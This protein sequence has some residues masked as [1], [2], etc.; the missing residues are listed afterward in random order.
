MSDLKLY[1]F[2]FE[3]GSG[4]LAYLILPDHAQEPAVIET[5]H[6]HSDEE[7]VFENVE[8]GGRSVKVLDTRL[9]LTIHD[10]K[11]PLPREKG[12]L[13]STPPGEPMHRRWSEPTVG[14]PPTT[15]PGGD[16]E[17]SP[18]PRVGV[19]KLTPPTRPTHTDPSPWSGLMARVERYLTDH[20]AQG[21]LFALG[22]PG[23]RY[24]GYP[25]VDSPGRWMA[26]ITWGPETGRQPV[27]SWGDT[28]EAAV[29]ALLWQLGI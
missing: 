16:V 7:L 6:R 8:D 29:E 12:H 11:T 2:E 1:T 27:R 14:N 21:V 22:A 17:I 15:N 5:T 4:D 23:V 25:G 26:R 3:D 10:E 24:D 19:T 13:M 9:G 20:E 28:M 18:R